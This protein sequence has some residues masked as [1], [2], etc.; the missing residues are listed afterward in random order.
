MSYR[1]EPASARIF[2][3]VPCY[4]GIDHHA[5]PGLLKAA[6]RGDAWNEGE[7]IPEPLISV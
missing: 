2:V 7:P 4:A 6:D 5:L 3:A 1:D